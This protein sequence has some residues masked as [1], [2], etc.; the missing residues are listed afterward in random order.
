MKE[1]VEDE[2][3]DGFDEEEDSYKISRYEITTYVTQRNID[4]LLKWVSVGKIVIPDFQRDYVW[5]KKTASKL[6][7]SILL[8]LPIPNIFLYKTVDK[9]EEK[10]YVIDGFQR[11]QTIKFFKDG[12]WNPNSDMKESISFNEEDSKIFKLDCKGSEWYNLTYNLLTESDKFNFEEY[13]IN[14]TI[15]EQTHPENKDSMFEVFERINTGAEKLSEQEI[16]NAIFGGPLLADIK[17]E[18]ENSNFSE[19]VKIDNHMRKRQNYVDLY[20]RFVTYLYMYRNDYELNGQKMTSSKRETLNNFCNYTNEHKEF[21]YKLYLDDV[22][23]AIECIYQF[24]DTAMYGKKRNTDE[25]SDRIHSVFAEALVLSVINNGFKINTTSQKFN[26]NKIALWKSEEFFNLFVQQTT[27][28][29]N[30]SARINKLLAMIN[31]EDE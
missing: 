13:N 9:G 10:Y 24:D 18:A 7:D 31:C 4:S 20:L 14:L 17:Y 26:E 22:S 28:P 6:I 3:F 1:N 21:D 12:I 8:N 29:A 25:I 11:I 16:R 2:M 27:T 30:I 15:F 19:I 23:K 5:T